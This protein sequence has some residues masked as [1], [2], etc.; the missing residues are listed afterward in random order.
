MLLFITVFSLHKFW[1]CRFYWWY[2][3]KLICLHIVQ[4]PWKPVWKFIPF[5]NV[6]DLF[7]PCL[8]CFLLLPF[9]FCIMSFLSL[10]HSFLLSFHP[11][12]NTQMHS[13]EVLPSWALREFSSSLRRDALL[14]STSYNSYNRVFAECLAGL[15][16]SKALCE[17]LFI[18][19]RFAPFPSEID[20]QAMCVL[21]TVHWMCLM[22]PAQAEMKEQAVEQNPP[23]SLSLWLTFERNILEGR[24]P[25]LGC[26][27]CCV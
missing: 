6:A 19:L 20:K 17:P 3:K 14:K 2:L 11:L 7:K 9:P 8:A 23:E 26:P 16:T 4:I 27:W 5:I 25:E 18:K 1:F 13:T 12:A 22:I 15:A 21:L 24:V 10:F